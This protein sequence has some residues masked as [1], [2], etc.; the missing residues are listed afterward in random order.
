MFSQPARLDIELPAWVADYARRYVPVSALAQRMAFVI[1][2]AR[3]NVEHGGGGPFAAAVIESVSGQLVSL[4]VN[5]VT[6]GSLSMLHAEMVAIALAQRKLGGYDLGGPGMPALELV[7]STEPCA[8]CFGAIPWSGVRRVVAGARDADARAIGFDE[9]P[10]PADW[11]A[12]LETR[13]IA[14]VTDIERDAA[15]AVLQDYRAAGGPI[16]NARRD[17]SPR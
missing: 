6:G 15:R 13:D 2:A 3:L 7:T 10:K 9:G 5:L 16:Y 14:V 1:A 11:A 12:A 17:T 8:M 4:G